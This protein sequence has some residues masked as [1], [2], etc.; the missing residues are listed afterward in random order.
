MASFFRVTD[1]SR[2]WIRERTKKC[3]NGVMTVARIVSTENHLEKKEKLKFGFACIE[4]SQVL[5]NCAFPISALYREGQY[6]WDW[7]IN[8][9]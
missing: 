9:C 2:G 7:S 5:K 8:F 6:V 3:R 1:D 4:F